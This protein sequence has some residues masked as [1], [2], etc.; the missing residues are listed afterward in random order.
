MS[1]GVSR[2]LTAAALILGAA[3]A[4]PWIWPPE[5]VNPEGS[6]PE[7][8]REPA[9]E[10][11]PAP[12]RETTPREPAARPSGSDDLKSWIEAEALRVG[13]LDDNPNESLRRMGKRAEA[14]KAP[15]VP[16]LEALALENGREGDRRFLAVELL[17]LSPL[18][19]SARALGRIAISG[20]PAQPLEPALETALRARALEGL[21]SHRSSEGRKV[22]RASLGRLDESFLVDRAQ[23][24]LHAAEGA[25]APPHE[26]DTRALETIL[27]TE[28]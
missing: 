21:G 14:L 18:P 26:Q 22:L 6:A 8:L 1:K 17:A 12:R 11:A 4:L 27:K 3:L 7:G 15:E 2:P 23:R 16:A 25:V 20:R 13:A 28:R 5:A 19:E 9:S 10:A 24:A